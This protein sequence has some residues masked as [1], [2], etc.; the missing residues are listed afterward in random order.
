MFSFRVEYYG[1]SSNGSL[2][3]DFIDSLTKIQKAKIMRIFRNIS[4]YGLSSIIPHVKKVTGTPLWEIRVLG[5]D[6]IRVIYAIAY[7]NFEDHLNE[8]LKDPNFQKAWLET[9]AEYLLAREMIEQRRKKKLS[10]RA[11]AKKVKIS[12]AA[13]SRI[14]A[15]NGNP[16]L[17]LLKRIAAALD[18]RLTIK[19]AP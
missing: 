14:E 15:M 6:N 10:Q 9:E 1:T 2:V 19:F 11:L 5:K 3:R 17:S 8:S 4:E 16:S 18:C 12:Q 7:G 13:I